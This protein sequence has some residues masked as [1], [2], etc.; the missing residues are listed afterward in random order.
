MKPDPIRVSS[1][2]S[3][4]ATLPEDRPA[5]VALLRDLG[6]EPNAEPMHLRWKYWQERAD[7][8]EPRSYVVT[9]GSALLAHAALIPLS[10]QAEGRELRAA[11]LIDWAARPGEPG[12]GAMLLRHAAACSD[13]LIGI[14]GSDATIKILPV[15][16]FKKCGAITGYVRTLRPLKLLAYAARPSWRLAPRVARS[17]LWCMTAPAQGFEQWRV[18]RIHSEQLGEILPLL[19]HGSGAVPAFERSEGLLRYVLSC[20]VVPMECFAVEQGAGPRGYFILA[21]VHGQARL[22]DAK[23][24]SD[25]P[26]D[27]RALIACAVREAKRDKAVAEIVTWASDSTMSQ[28]LRE[29]GF[30]PRFVAPFWARSRNTSAFPPSPF[31]VQMLDSD[32]AYLHEGRGALWV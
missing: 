19:R 27:W 31:R 7:C 11:H 5:I 10:Y 29:S 3:V 14:G 28:C 16:G 24:D 32:A 30:H 25:A 17:A 4:R 22:V 8:R 12:T 2:Y 13:A 23:L 26:A 1:R 9:D 6:L 21:S 15:L 18:R 20:P